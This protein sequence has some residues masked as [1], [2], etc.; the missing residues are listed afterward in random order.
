MVQLSRACCRLA[1]G[2]ARTASRPSTLACRPIAALVSRPP[3]RRP[4]HSTRNRTSTTSDSGDS[5]SSGGDGYV[6]MF[7]YPFGLGGV[8]ALLA[9]YR[10][11]RDPSRAGALV[12][13][14][15]ASLAT[16]AHVL[17]LD[18]HLQGKC[19][20][21]PRLDAIYTELAGRVDVLQAKVTNLQ[22]T[23][24][25]EQFD[26]Q[27]V[28]YPHPQPTAAADTDTA[29]GADADAGATTHSSDAG[30]PFSAVG[31]DGLRF[32]AHWSTHRHAVRLELAPCAFR[33][34][35]TVTP[36]RVVRDERGDAVSQDLATVRLLETTGGEHTH[37]DADVLRALTRTCGGP[38]MTARQFVWFLA[39]M[40]S[41]PSDI[42]F[43]VVSGALMGK[44]VTS[45]RR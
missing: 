16:E 17:D 44:P 37:L 43:D 35:L 18:R 13:E 8:D 11:T 3:N 34:T 9:S 28:I 32:S 15:Q 22:D 19:A 38:A 24:L 29:A 4:L 1:I 6:G 2:T 25:M 41:H 42:A 31:C 27:F 7:S 5:S 12:A 21:D 14:L 39:F 40:A 33:A 10:S 20:S 36:F 30:L 45:L 26:K 23:M